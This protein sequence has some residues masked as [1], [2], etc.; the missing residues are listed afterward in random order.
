MIFFGE[1]QRI[2]IEKKLSLK[3]GDSLFDSNVDHWNKNDT[4]VERS[5]LNHNQIIILIEAKSFI[6]ETIKFGVYI[7]LG[8]NGYGELRDNKSFVFT[9]R[10]KNEPK[11]YMIKSGKVAFQLHRKDDSDNKLFT[12]GNNEIIIRNKDAQN[13]LVISQNELSSFNFPL[14]EPYALVGQEGIIPLAR[15]VIIKMENKTNKK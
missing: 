5:L 12:I 15:F 11:K 6:G 2:Q 4:A 1:K 13:Q 10:N 9:F 8:I 3:V 14:N 7:K